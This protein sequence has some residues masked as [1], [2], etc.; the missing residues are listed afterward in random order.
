MFMRCLVF[1]GLGQDGWTGPGRET[2]SRKQ[3][4]SPPVVFSVR[5]QKRLFFDGIARVQYL[6]IMDLAIR[7][8]QK[9]LLD[10]CYFAVDA[11]DSYLLILRRDN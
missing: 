2:W 4:V 3:T 1:F 5:R 6:L 11:G 8:I 10:E 9:Y 7:Y